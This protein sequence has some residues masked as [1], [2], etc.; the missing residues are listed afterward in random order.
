MA[1]KNL[2]IRRFSAKNV[3]YKISDEK[4]LFLLIQPSEPGFGGSNIASV[5]LRRS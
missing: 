1:L 3:P 2:E 5:G 4:G